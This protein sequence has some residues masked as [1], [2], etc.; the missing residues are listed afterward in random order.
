[1]PE[2]SGGRALRSEGRVG[3]VVGWVWFGEG[4]LGSLG[5]IFPPPKLFQ[6]PSSL[7]QY[8]IQFGAEWRL[9]GKEQDWGRA[10]GARG[11]WSYVDDWPFVDAGVRTSDSLITGV[12]EDAPGFD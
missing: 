12:D 5:R 4:G 7:G 10:E 9:I 6:V 3:F 2:E 1:M 11:L 8:L